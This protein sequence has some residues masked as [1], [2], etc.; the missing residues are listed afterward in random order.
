MPSVVQVNNFQ[1]LLGQLARGASRAVNA[2]WHGD[3]DHYARI[4][5]PYLAASA[6]VSAHWY[7]SLA[8]NVPFAAAPGPLPPPDALAKNA[9]YAL[10]TADPNGTLA[11]TTERHVYATS[12]ATIVHNADR[13]NV[14]YA[15]YASASACAFCRVLAT[16]NTLYTSA[17]AAVSVVGKNGRP[18][19][20]RA[21]GSLYHD[22]CHCIAVPVRPGD[23]YQPPDYVAQWEKDYQAARDDPDTKG[24]DDIV[25]HMRRTQYARDKSPFKE[26]WQE[27]ERS[28]F[29]ALSQ[30]PAPA[31]VT[32]KPPEL[33][34]RRAPDD[35]F[36]QD[37]LDA[38]NPG[39]ASGKS[40]SRNNCTRCATAV[41]L[42]HRGYDVTANPKPDDVNDNDLANVLNKWTSPD[43]SVAGTYNARGTRPPRP[44][45]T[46]GMGAG[47]R[48][49]HTLPKGSGRANKERID[50]GVKEWGK[51][52]RGYVVVMWKGRKTSHIFNVENR[53]GTIVYTDG[54]NGKDDASDYF[55]RASPGA[56]SVYVVRTD[57]LTPREN[58]T[59]WVRS[60][61][62]AE[63]AAG[64]AASAAKKRVA[65]GPQ[66]HDVR[67]AAEA[68][69]YGV[70]TG[71]MG[72][73]AR[74]ALEAQ[75]G[76]AQI[77]S[78]YSADPDVAEAYMKGIF[79]YRRWRDTEA[80]RQ[81]ALARAKVEA[82]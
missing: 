61:T 56:D 27:K 79:W 69:G 39:Y 72:H 11:G 25:N 40:E 54:Q 34:L 23:D 33:S 81:A 42:R 19:G 46:L 48:V 59:D 28:P 12:G 73:F 6:Q 66:P 14:R 16:R 52:S 2:G 18:R 26:L 82:K 80:A 47:N 36:D 17:T 77:P 65:A 67:D 41:E 3:P 5:D 21:I 63:V 10:G 60:R 7:H 53:D 51:D 24:F 31:P 58:V 49:F 29:E 38:V 1:R 44:G 74:G 9:A 43:G 50:A 8:P 62:D 55:N 76:T 20:T 30:E 71:K 78:D 35:V 64:E 75:K 57:D 15:R 68:R 22:R 32:T 70:D 13:E 37:D 4:V 45:E